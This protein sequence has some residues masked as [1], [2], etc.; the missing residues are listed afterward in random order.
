MWVAV[1]AWLRYR[2]HE[3]VLYILNRPLSIEDC[4][5]RSSM[6]W[7]TCRILNSAVLNGRQSQERPPSTEGK[8]KKKTRH[9]PYPGY[10]RMIG[11]D[12]D[13]TKVANAR[14][15]Q[16]C[17]FLGR[18]AC[19]YAVVLPVLLH[20]QDK[21]AR[22]PSPIL[23]PVASLPKLTDPYRRNTRALFTL[24][25]VPSLTKRAPGNQAYITGQWGGVARLLPVA[26]DSH[27]FTY[28][29]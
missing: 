19:V 2:L 6:F 21:T 3:A 27:R 16:L 14:G 26:L 7:M 15:S 1:E 13:N 25:A 22:W 5:A 12:H 8:K 29:A 4:L 24:V 18:R 10:P 23:V 9:A 17:I 20:W 11:A 28:T